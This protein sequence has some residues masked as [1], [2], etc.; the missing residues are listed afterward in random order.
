MSGRPTTSTATTDLIPLIDMDRWRSG[1]ADERQR[2]AEDVDAALADVGFLI[3]T[4]HGI[5]VSLIDDVRTASAEAFALPSDTKLK[6][7]QSNGT[8]GPGWTPIGAEANS[9]ASGQA[10][11][12]D[13]KETWTVSPVGEGAVVP[14]SRGVIPVSN[15]FPVEV[16]AF[17]PAMERYLAAGLDLSAELF[18]LLAVAAG[19]P[20][21]RF[22]KQCTEPLHNFNLTWY[23]P[24]GD[25]MADPEPGQ[26]RI[27]PHS[28]FGTITVLQREASDP[29]LQVQR[30]DGSWVDLPHV[31][32]ALVVNTG[33][34]LAYWS[35]GRWRSN[36]HRIPAPTGEAARQGRLSLVLFLETDVGAM[37][38][39][40]GRPDD[41]PMDAVQYLIDKLIAIDTSLH[42]D[43]EPT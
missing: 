16:P 9:Y 27:G 3:I 18:E 29:P 22:A 28:D 42:H 25:D 15:E 43:Q 11:P 39:P 17:E 2:T 7:R 32:D 41:E 8:G 19:L 37:L 33:D 5:A 6:Y 21:D 30:S 38:Q 1:S 4:N 34:Q 35:G 31:P 36:P 14:T 26:F 40:I 23:P 13:L 24:I 12:P 20:T 10:A